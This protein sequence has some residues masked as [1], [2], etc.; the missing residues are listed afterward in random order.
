MFTWLCMCCR[1]AGRDSTCTSIPCR[2][3]VT[4]VPCTTYS[5]LGT[6]YHRHTNVWMHYGKLLWDKNT[7]VGIPQLW[8]I[9][10]VLSSLFQRTEPHVPCGIPLCYSLR[11]TIVTLSTASEQLIPHTLYHNYSTTVVQGVPLDLNLWSKLSTLHRPP[12]GAVAPA[13]W[14]IQTHGRVSQ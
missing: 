7:E 13:L 12:G 10:S 3:H 11:Y 4:C 14:G 8:V 6:L 9:Q 5:T 1:S 2:V